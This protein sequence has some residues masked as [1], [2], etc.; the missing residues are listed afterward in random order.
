MV[1]E[2]K[3]KPTFTQCLIHETKSACVPYFKWLGIIT[4]F[5]LVMIGI[6]AAV[7][8]LPYEIIGQ[9]LKIV[10]WYVYALLLI[11]SPPCIYALV[12]CLRR[13]T[14]KA[15]VS[16]AGFILIMLGGLFLFVGI[17]MSNTYLGI[18]AVICGFVGFWNV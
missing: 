17:V 7:L 13:R 3:P 4:V 14:D 18:M 11:L 1:D 6:T 2:I 5:L 10:P 15:S 12:E 16:L 9:Y 8:L